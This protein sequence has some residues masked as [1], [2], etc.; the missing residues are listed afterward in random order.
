M[1]DME[2]ISSEDEHKRMM[3]RRMDVRRKKDEV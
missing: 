1:N 2:M 3:K